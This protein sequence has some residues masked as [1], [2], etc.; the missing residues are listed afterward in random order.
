M[1]PPKSVWDERVTTEKGRQ[2]DPERC[3]T[4][5]NDE[6]GPR[7]CSIPGLS[8]WCAFSFLAVIFET[9]TLDTL[10]KPALGKGGDTVRLRPCETDHA[11]CR[12]SQGGLLP[13]ES[14]LKLRGGT[15]FMEHGPQRR[16]EGRWGAPR[17][18]EVPQALPCIPEATLRFWFCLYRVRLAGGILCTIDS[19]SGLGWGRWERVLNGEY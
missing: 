6:T 2:H 12:P 3:W 14:V 1:P 18:G 10:P 15:L 13:D 4:K 7:V 16:A 9:G 8:P 5:H 11:Q 19:I 17:F